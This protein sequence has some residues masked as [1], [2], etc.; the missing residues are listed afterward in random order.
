MPKVIRRAPVFLA[1]AFPLSS[2]AFSCS[3]YLTQQ[4]ATISFTLFIGGYSSS[5]AIFRKK[6]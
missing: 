4:R 2:A 5:Y 6:F 1:Y 3:V